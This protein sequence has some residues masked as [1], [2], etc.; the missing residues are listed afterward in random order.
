MKKILF[1]IFWFA[2][3]T[4]GL[5]DAKGL[6]CISVTLHGDE[7]GPRLESPQGLRI[8]GNP[9]TRPAWSDGKQ[10]YGDRPV[11]CGPNSTP[12]GIYNTELARNAA[13]SY[14]SSQSHPWY[15]FNINR[16]AGTMDVT[17]CQ[18]AP[19]QQLGINQELERFMDDLM[20]KPIL[21]DDI[22]Q[23][24][25]LD[26]VLSYARTHGYQITDNDIP[27]IPASDQASVTASKRDLTN[28]S[29]GG[30]GQKPCNVSVCTASIT[31]YFPFGFCCIPTVSDCTATAYQSKCKNGYVGDAF[32]HCTL[33]SGVTVNQAVSAGCRTADEVNAV[34]TNALNNRYLGSKTR[35][36]I[37]QFGKRDNWMTKLDVTDP[38]TWGYRALTIIGED[39]VIV[40]GKLYSKA[41]RRLSKKSKDKEKEFWADNGPQINRPEQRSD[42][43]LTLQMLATSSSD[44]PPSQFLSVALSYDVASQF[45]F[46][47]DNIV[48]KFQMTP[49]SPVLGMTNCQLNK[50]EVQIQVPGNTPIRNLQR[51]NK[52]KGYW[53]KYQNG[54]WVRLESRL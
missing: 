49:N 34:I 13:Q 35:D 17:C 31:H 22:P 45:G 52:K 36:K 38:N 51:F 19:V 32:G 16:Q 46:D 14:C 28:D 41:L 6:E 21:R 7:P 4:V 2:F 8:V 23:N 37:T 10:T 12:D 48:Y 30:M 33:R 25:S 5:Y 54:Q 18:R 24:A 11:C 3:L 20:N 39:K 47:N 53:E 40:T 27:T 9:G 42:V 43:A 1:L 15:G 50:G 26:Q 29:C 44:E